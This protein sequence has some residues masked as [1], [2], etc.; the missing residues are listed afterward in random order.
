MTSLKMYINGVFYDKAMLKSVKDL[1]VKETENYYGDV[2][3]YLSRKHKKDIKSLGIQ[4]DFYVQLPSLLN[5]MYVSEIEL[6]EFDEE[7]KR[8]RQLVRAV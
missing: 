2:A 5:E 4:P 7:I 8:R 1:S 3:A 6:T